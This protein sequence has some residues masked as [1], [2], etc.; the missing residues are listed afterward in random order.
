MKLTMRCTTASALLF[1]PTILRSQAAP[2]IVT[3]RTL[4]STDSL[5]VAAVPVLLAGSREA[6]SDGRGAFRI[7]G[8]APGS[9]QISVDHFGYKP[10]LD[11]VDVVAGQ[12]VGLDLY[13]TRDTTLISQLKVNGRSVRVPSGFE[14]VYERVAEAQGLLITREQ[15]DSSNARDIAGLLRD[16]RDV[17]VNLN[18]NA[19]DRI[20]TSNCRPT[21]PGAD[22]TGQPTR[23]IFNGAPVTQRAWLNDV[24]TNIAPSMVQAIEIYNGSITVPPRFQPACG[25]IAIWTRKQ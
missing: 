1:L 22:V 8:V 20:T 17:R 7:A 25:V 5:V 2:G 12:T 13:L 3:G 10:F 23:V 4:D 14:V 9:H 24:L 11:R 16:V 21:L 19:T 18:S 6:R 15:I